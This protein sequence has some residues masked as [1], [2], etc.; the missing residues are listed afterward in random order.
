[1]IGGI[2]LTC[3]YR[4]AVLGDVNGTLETDGVRTGEKNRVDVEL[5]T[6]RTAQFLLYPRLE[7][8]HHL[9]TRLLIHTTSE[10]QLARAIGS[11]ET[12]TPVALL[13]FN[14]QARASL[15]HL[16]QIPSL[17]PAQ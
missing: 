15:L 3:E 9:V 17:N 12:Y 7:L 5:T 1:L 2:T 8:H 14:G 10:C 4:G 16:T 6:S 13:S 11:C